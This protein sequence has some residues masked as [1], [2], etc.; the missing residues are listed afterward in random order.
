M[1]SSSIAKVKIVGLD[2]DPEKEYAVNEMDYATYK[3]DLMH[4]GK[5]S[6]NIYQ[7]GMELVFQQVEPSFIYLNNITNDYHGETIGRYDYFAHGKIQNIKVYK[8]NLT[9]S[10]WFLQVFV[11]SAWKYKV[12]DKYV[13]SYKHP[14]TSGRI[15]YNQKLKENNN[16]LSSEISSV[17]DVSY[18]NALNI[19]IHDAIM[20]SYLYFLDD[21][22]ERIK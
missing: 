13:G 18:E 2:Y 22:Q 16:L 4:D 3:K 15:A 1:D 21:S 19:A 12:G 20:S 7:T 9:E 5:L 6:E 8:V 10:E 17:E 14:G 11:E